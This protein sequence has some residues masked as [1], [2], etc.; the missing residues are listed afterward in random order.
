MRYFFFFYN[1]MKN[2]NNFN[3]SL[4]TKDNI[5]YF[6]DLIKN[7]RLFRIGN[8]HFFKITNMKIEL[9]R[10][11]LEMLD[12]N[13]AYI[14]LPVLV[15]D[16]GQII[17]LSHQILVSKNSNSNVINNFIFSKLEEAVLSYGWDELTEYTVVFKFR[18][19]SF[20]EN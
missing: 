5:T 8:Y 17:S 14:V 11:F 19:I 6:S 16:N 4:L 10:E 7:K 12:N 15:N 13:K 20:K 9:L 2:N 3:I 18:A 1:I